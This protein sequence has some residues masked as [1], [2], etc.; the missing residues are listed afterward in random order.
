MIAQPRRINLKVAMEDV[1][2]EMDVAKA[3]EVE[4]MA[5]VAV[6]ASKRTSSHLNPVNLIPGRRMAVPKSGVAFMVIGRGVTKL[7]KL[8]IVLIAPL[9][10]RLATWQEMVRIHP[11]SHKTAAELLL[12]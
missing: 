8:R 9:E 4:D 3:E 12:E 10:T 6:V 7:T 11:L 1:D 5:A 2:V